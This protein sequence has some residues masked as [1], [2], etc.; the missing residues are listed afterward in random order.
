MENASNKNMVEAVSKK[1]VKVSPR[2][3]VFMGVR[4]SKKGKME[5]CESHNADHG[6]INAS[7]HLLPKHLQ[8]KL[9]DHSNGI[10]DCITKYSIPYSDGCRI[11]KAS[12]YPKLQVELDKRKAAYKIFVQDEIIANYD[13]IIK[14]AQ[15]RLNG[16]Y[17]DG[18]FPNKDVLAS[19][20]GVHLIV[21]PMTNTDDVN[22][23]IEGL[24]QSQI[25]EIRANL[26]KEIEQNLKEGQMKAV[27]E[28]REAVN[29][30]FEKTKNEDGSRYKAAVRN[31]VDL[32]NNVENTNVL[33]IPE[34]TQVAQD[35][36]KKLGKV[37][38]SAIKANA[39]A[40]KKVAKEAVDLMAAID[41]ISL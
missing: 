29:N 35:I 25:D 32:C 5:L 39:G 23:V 34:L 41:A 19:K 40:A 26:R 33:E 22:F 36:K 16:L 9:R 14:M 20:Y 30:I 28:L 8:K 7:V 1:L 31:L 37:S 17:V 3:S 18:M 13:S 4:S 6:A 10:R 11:M 38:G 2:I 27:N 12:N 21:E 15:T 24:N